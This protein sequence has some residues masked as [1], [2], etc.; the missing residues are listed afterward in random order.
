MSCAL[1]PCALIPIAL[2]QGAVTLLTGDSPMVSRA[3]LTGVVV[4]GQGSTIPF[5]VC[6]LVLGYLGY[7]FLAR[8]FCMF[9]EDFDEVFDL[10]GDEVLECG[11]ENP[12]VCESCE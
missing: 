4:V 6:C 5:F 1:R 7:V 3:L 2:S 10:D 9:F 8:R 11:I 12:E